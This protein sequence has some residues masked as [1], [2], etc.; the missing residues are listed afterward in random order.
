[1][2][3]QAAG[4]NIKGKP[5][6]I[7]IA[8][9][10]GS[11]KTTFTGK[12]AQFLKKKKGKRVLM[13]ACDV[14]RPAAIN[15]LSVLAEQVG[16]DIYK[17]EANKNP[18]EIAKN[19]VEHATKMGMDV[20]IIDTAGRLA[21]DEEMMNEIEAI[22]KAIQPT[23]SLFVVDSMTGQDAVNTAKT[24]NERIDYNGVVLTKMDGDTRGGAALTIKYTVGKP[25]KFVSNGE[26]MGD[27]DV[28]HPERIADRILGMGD[29]LSLVEKAQE[30]FDEKEAK[31]LESKIKKNKFDFN[32]FMVQMGQIKKMGNIKNLISMIPGMSK[33]TKN[34]DIDDNAFNKLEAIIN[35]MTP[36]ERKNPSIINGSRK[37]RI[38]MGSGNKLE[39]INQFMRQFDQMRKM[40]HQM[41]KMQGKGGMNMPNF[42]R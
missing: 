36:E 41:S 1:M 11:G 14:Y 40:M 27:L 21:V 23:E 39:E 32:D 5:G 9:L 31:R 8:G 6:I 33:M 18:V 16:V 37:K 28:F 13:T 26:K 30:Q 19:A 22:N 20:V 38:A 42:P 7:L 34:L 29:I 4:I 12:L 2:G 35:S 25:I 3:G 15:Q 17:E 10:Q 24:F